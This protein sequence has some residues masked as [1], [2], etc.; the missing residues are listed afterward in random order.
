MEFETDLHCD[1]SA[2]STET[3]PAVAAFFFAASRPRVGTTDAPHGQFSLEEH[4]AGAAGEQA[5]LGQ[6]L[7]QQQFLLHY[8]PKVSC[9]TGKITGMEALLRWNHPQR[10]L[11]SPVEFI[12]RLEETG[13]IIEVGA[14]VLR[15]AC[16]QTAGW[17]KAGLGT[18]SI[19]VN[20]SGR[21]L[22]SDQLFEVV[23]GALDDSGLAARYLELELTESFLVEDPEHAVAVLSRLKTLGLKVSVDD[24]GTGYSSLAYLKRFPL[25]SLKVDRAFVRDIIA[26]PH[27]VSITRAI[28]N[29]AHN[30]KLSVVAEGVET[31]G[32]LGLLTANGCD[33]IQGYYFSPPIP[34]EQFEAML[35]GGKS[36]PAQL[37]AD[38]QAGRT[39][40][41]VDD[42]EYILNALKRLLRRSNY[43]VL[44]APSA[45]E[46]LRLLGENRVDVVISDQRMP[47]MT[48][49]EFLSRVKE[50]HPDSV[51]MVL[52]GYTD[53]ESVTDAINRGAI[54]K[55]LTKPWDDEHLLANIEEAFRRKEIA[56]ENR[57]LN[58][59]LASTNARLGTVNDELQALL[60]EN[61]QQAERDQITLRVMQEIVQH[62]PT[63]LIGID[64]D[65]LIALSNHAADALLTPQAS[66]VGRGVEEALPRAMLS[67]LEGGCRE[68][69]GG[70]F[71][72]SRYMVEGRRMGGQSGSRG[73]L[74]VFTPEAS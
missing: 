64:Q 7:A 4:G 54:Y 11:V 55:F 22:Q 57:R 3:K 24:F 50:I 31:E 21:Q 30:L 19:A 43:R 40:L 73:L 45:A 18:P 23:R 69:F 16:L 26:D 72:A 74:L 25:D 28:I 63:P 66:L 27:D 17:H 15:A 67:W 35:R 59:E 65:G 58:Q 14:W 34:A 29:L 49:V 70:E 68:R 37:I 9:H 20:V 62:V 52:S 53:L 2:T 8:Q 36:L 51:R 10:G 13:M 12:P 42:E 71:C 56:D 32:Q 48:G 60:R 47:V 5:D 44:T 41:L 46:G 61:G 6:A 33:M 1:A 39:L 38:R